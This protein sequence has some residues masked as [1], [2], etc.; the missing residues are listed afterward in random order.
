M[1]IFLSSGSIFPLSVSQAIRFAR[2]AGYD[3][4]E[5]VNLYGWRN[6]NVEKY[7]EL[8]RKYELALHFHEVWSLEDNPT[9]KINHFLNLLGRLPPT[10]SSLERQFGGVTEP[11]VVYPHR[12]KEVLD[13][14]NFWLQTCS[15][16]RDGKLRSSY[17]EFLKIIIKNRLPVVFDTQHYLEWCL[18]T[19]GVENIPSD[20]LV[21]FNLLQQGWRVLGQYVKEIHLNDFSPSL[22]HEMGRNLF[23]GTG[24]LPLREFASLVRQSGWDGIIVPEISPTHILSL[25]PGK[26]VSNLMVLREKVKKAF[27]SD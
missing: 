12:W 18:V 5:V 2:D 15:V 21:L 27:P 19:M 13:K 23:L 3:G 9:H 25:R 11:V 17:G 8:A 10:D 6:K 26:T 20:S 1:K 7:R 4:V 22:G 14:R 24:V 16:H